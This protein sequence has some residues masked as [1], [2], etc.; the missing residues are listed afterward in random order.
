MGKCLAFQ[1]VDLYWKMCFLKILSLIILVLWL[2]LLPCYRLMLLPFLF[3]ILVDVITKIDNGIYINNILKYKI[4]HRVVL[5][6]SMN[7]SG[8]KDTGT[9]N[10]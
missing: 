8:S 7:L 6:Q 5:L 10:V 2:M 9:E 4:C 1:Y 3:E